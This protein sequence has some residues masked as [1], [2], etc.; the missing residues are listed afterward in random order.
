MLCHLMSA[1][2]FLGFH[3]HLSVK[4]F[5]EIQK[6]AC[7]LFSQVMKQVMPQYGHLIRK[8]CIQITKQQPN[9]ASAWLTF[10]LGINGNLSFLNF[11]CN[12]YEFEMATCFCCHT[13]YVIIS[14][15][16]WEFNI[17]LFMLSQLSL[18]LKTNT[19]NEFFCSV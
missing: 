10:L 4:T 1:D 14:Q 5:K 8:Y 12:C 11:I 13:L 18:I 6:M 16:F 19:M 3:K 9:M 17:L 2:I 7:C 15:A